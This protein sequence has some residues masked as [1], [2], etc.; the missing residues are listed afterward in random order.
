MLPYPGMSSTKYKTV[1]PIVNPILHTQS[2]LDLE[3]SSQ[4]HYVHAVL[5]THVWSLLLMQDHAEVLS[6]QQHMRA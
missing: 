2:R 6:G 5:L 4:I 3:G 1:L